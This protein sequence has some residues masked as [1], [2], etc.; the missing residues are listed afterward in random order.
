MEE[1][2]TTLWT[3]VKL[4][5]LRPSPRCN[6]SCLLPAPVHPKCMHA[7]GTHAVPV[8]PSA[9]LSL[10]RTLKTLPPS[11][12]WQEGAHSPQLCTLTESTAPQPPRP[13]PLATPVHFSNH[14]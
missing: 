3:K 10:A 9:C 7:P 13:D 12:Q 5:P 14:D 8:G 4:K 2:K 11:A 1:L 6:P